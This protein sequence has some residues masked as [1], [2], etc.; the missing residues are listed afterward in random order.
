MS[1]NLRLGL[2]IILALALFSVGIFWIGKK[3]FL[4]RSTYQLSADFPN[5]A[6]LIVGSVVRVGGTQQ[7][8]VTH[9]NLP[10]RPDQNVHVVMDLTDGTRQVV[11]HDSTASISSEGLVGDKYV[12]V[13]FGS[14]DSPPVKDGERIKALPPLQIS[15]LIEKTN[16]VL[17]TA[18]NSMDHVETMAENLKLIT[19]K[20]N[21]GK[22][23]AGA[24]INDKS[25]YSNMNAGVNA[26]QEDMQALKKNFLLRGFFKDRGY[27]DS[28]ELTKNQI[29]QLP[30]QP[31][32]M[33]F[34]YDGEELFDKPATAKL[35]KEKLLTEAGRY[36]EKTPFSLAVIA[37]D[38]DM[39]G[40]SDKDRILTQARATV[41]R[42]YLARNFRIDDKRLKTIGL[43]KSSEVSSTS[44]LQILVFA[45]TSAKP[46]ALEKPR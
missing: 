38:T 45:I 34:V 36:L 20:I 7:G 11:R 15:D 18:R 44:R 2:F 16:G 28:T 33:K 22:G 30:S 8:T 5:V 13:S 31:P 21:D 23:T 40:E 3:Q 9:I 29:A 32:M 24:L 12:E 1:R 26:M 17:D 42:A 19:G 37:A 39:K 25:L 35:K 6:G 10:P 43:G 46:P 14:P 4:F 27:E 41:A